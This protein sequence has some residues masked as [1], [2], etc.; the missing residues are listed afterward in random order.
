MKKHWLII[1][2]FFLD[3]LRFFHI[4]P[5]VWYKAELDLAKIQGKELANFF[6]KWSDDLE[7]RER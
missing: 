1:Q 2:V 5:N 7:R 4:L 3:W 6:K